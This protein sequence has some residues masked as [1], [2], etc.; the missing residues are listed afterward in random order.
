MAFADADEPT[1]LRLLLHDQ[2]INLLKLPSHSLDLTL[3]LGRLV[4][5]L[6]LGDQLITEV[7]I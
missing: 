4:L 2:P 7:Y 5:H 3:I 1:H 6:L